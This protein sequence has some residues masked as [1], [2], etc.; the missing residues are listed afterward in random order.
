[1][2]GTKVR[3]FGPLHNVSLENL[4]PKDHFYRHVERSLNLTFV[5]DLVTSCYA[6]NGRPSVDP[7]VFFKLQ[8]A[9]FFEGIRSERQLMEIAADRLSLRWFLGYDLHEKLADHSSLTKIRNRYGVA[10]FR[11]FFDRIVE[12][13]Q[14]AGLVWGKESSGTAR[15]TLSDALR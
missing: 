1:M 5:R 14:Q 7:V 8:L 12:E 11:R 9:M 10:I 4:D 3:L 15:L 13:C 2:M 6:P